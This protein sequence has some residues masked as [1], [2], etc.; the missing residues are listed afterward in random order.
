MDEVYLKY[1]E[2]LLAELDDFS[3]KFSDDEILV[4]QIKDIV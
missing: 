2:N 3:N 4:H 1:Y